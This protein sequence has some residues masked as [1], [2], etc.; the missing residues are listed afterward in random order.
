MVTRTAGAG[1]ARECKAFFCV[2]AL[3]CCCILW[4]PHPLD[5]YPGR[6]DMFELRAQS[7]PWLFSSPFSLVQFWKELCLSLALFPLPCWI[8]CSIMANWQSRSRE[9]GILP[10]PLS[11]FLDLDFWQLSPTQNPHKLVSFSFW[12]LLLGGKER[13]AALTALN[14]D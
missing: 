12:N 1:S 5:H 11:G 8:F 7:L 2:C 13:V 6:W 14:S 9:T 3:G 10:L 4:P